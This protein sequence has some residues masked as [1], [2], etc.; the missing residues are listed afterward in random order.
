MTLAERTRETARKYPFLMDALA[1][2]VCNYT[3]AA[4]FLSV[5]ETDED[6]VEAVATALRRF[7]A[8][9]DRT[10]EV[11]DARVTIQGGVTVGTNGNAD[12]GADTDTDADTVSLGVG[13][14]TVTD[15]GRE[16][17]VRATGDVDPTTLRTVLNR[18]TSAGV[19]ADAAGVAGKD[20][21]VVVDRRDGADAVRTMEA[22]LEAVAQT[23]KRGDETV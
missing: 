19:G 4:R 3:A 23:D 9:L 1:T 5:P 8:E 2:G 17:A 16:T 21:V 10:V 7:A 6:D 15:G 12:S 13:E 20:L 14:A 18:L 11:R 22:A